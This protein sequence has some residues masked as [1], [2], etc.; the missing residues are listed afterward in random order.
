MRTVIERSVVVLALGLAVSSLAACAQG[1]A[2]NTSAAM[3]LDNA[4]SVVR[5][6]KE[7]LWEA[8]QVAPTPASA[9]PAY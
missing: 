4:G 7:K 8:P 3:V 1:T 5:T 2:A 6:G 9:K